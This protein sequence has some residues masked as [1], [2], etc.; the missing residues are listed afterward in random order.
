MTIFLC[1]NKNEKKWNS[2]EI[3]QTYVETKNATRSS[4]YEQSLYNFLKNSDFAFSP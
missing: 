4:K 1:E 2:V 3:T